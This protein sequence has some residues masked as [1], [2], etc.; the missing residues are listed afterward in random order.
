[1][2]VLAQSSTGQ[3]GGEAAKGKPAKGGAGGRGKRGPV[4]IQ[5]ATIVHAT[6]EQRVS[7]VGNLLA[8]RSVLLKPEIDGRIAQVAI[9]DGET[10][11]AGQLVFKLDTKVVDAQ[12]SQA[13]A[14]L[15]LANNNLRRT[16]N[17]AK[18]NFVS[19]RSRD[20]AAA[21]AAVL[22]ARLEVMKA[23]LAQATIVAPFPG[24][25]G[26]VSVNTGDYVKSGAELVRLDDLSSLKLDIRVPERLFAELKVGQ[27]V[28]VS[29]DAYPK[30]SF[31]AK[32]ETIDSQIDQAGR[33]VTVR[34][35][36]NNESG[37]LR[38]GM[39]AKAALVLASRDNAMLVPETAIIPGQSGKVVYRVVD[40][41]ATRTPIKTGIRQD[42]NIEVLDGLA[43]GDQV[44]TAGLIKMRGPSVKVR[45]MPGK[46]QVGSKT[47][48]RQ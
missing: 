38:P 24:R 26:L 8:A 7:A 29:I 33:A 28:R 17:L 19:R 9:T 32:V 42:G 47:A 2:S 10:V 15:R 36:L 21:N 39:F 12:V 43:L 22:R 31:E 11:Q 45:L 1:M 13:K 4:A 48:Q 27:P 16:R 18:Q 30:Q 14:E 40:G 46:T 20:E 6:V 37:L 23:Q 41:T 3:P 25:V 34:G 5:T 35:R 44:V